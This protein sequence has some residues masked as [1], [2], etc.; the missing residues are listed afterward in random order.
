MKEMRFEFSFHKNAWGFMRACDGLRDDSSMD[1]RGPMAGMPSLDKLPTVRVLPHGFED[2]L[3][4]LA[5]EHSA[6]PAT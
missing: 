3:R 1:R 5:A 4:A 2:R 6:L